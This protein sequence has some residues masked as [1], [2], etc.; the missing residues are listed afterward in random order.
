MILVLF[1]RTI[2]AHAWQLGIENYGTQLD[3]F[4]QKRGALVANQTS[5]TS[6][7]VPTLTVLQNAGCTITTLLA[8]EHGFTGTTA[9]GAAVPNEIHGPTG[10][11]VVSLYAG[12]NNAHTIAPEL[13]G[14]IDV[15]YVDLPH[16]GMRHYTYISTLFTIMQSAAN[17]HVH[18]VV[19]DRP[20][21]L[22]PLMEGPLVEPT[23]KSFISIAS[24]P[25]RYALSMGELARYFN[26]LLTPPANLTV[27]PMHGY[28][29]TCEVPH[30]QAPLSPNVPTRTSCYGYS[31][32]GL[33][34]EIAPCYAGSNGTKQP[35]TYILL[36]EKLHISHRRWQRLG[37]LLTRYHI[38]SS[39]TRIYRTRT[40]TWY[41]GLSLQFDALATTRSFSLL[42][43]ILNLFDQWGVPLKFS[44][45]FDKAIG[46]PLVRNYL[47]KTSSY[48]EL[49]T[50]VNR[51]LKQFFYSVEPLLLYEPAPTLALLRMN[52]PTGSAMYAKRYERSHAARKSS[53]S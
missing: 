4:K 34:E 38:R 48:A 28:R 23:L 21:P 12:G 53:I 31:F 15:I 3:Q 26:T 39:P 52:Q 25:L 7:G 6:T 51:G 47:Q 49:V 41:T 5:V 9:A 46:T 22:G 1:V 8:P 32:L 37:T 20:N 2:S 35:F 10:I 40:K 14:T 13:F 18:V 11:P 44:Q 24:I 45:S 33:L 17:A 27:I 30:F 50:A 19:F 29:R 42:L 43:N 36:P 16:C